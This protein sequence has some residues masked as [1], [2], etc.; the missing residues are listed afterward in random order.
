MFAV[1][2]ITDLF[3][4]LLFSRLFAREDDR[5]YLFNPYLLWAGR[6]TDPVGR[7]VTD[8]LPG[9]T[10]RAA[11]GIAFL[12]LLAF[13]GA[14]LTFASGSDWNI[15]VGSTLAFHPR[16]GW[17]GAIAFSFLDFIV[18]LV[19]FWGLALLVA[20][21]QS[22][23]TAAPRMRQALDA[24][25]A[26]LANGPAW[27][28]LLAILTANILLAPLLRHLATV[29]LASPASPRIAFSA[30]FHASPPPRLAAAYAGVALLSLAD[31][32]AFL[33]GALIIAIFSSLLAAIFRNRTLATFFLELQNLLLGRFSRRQIGVGMFDF[34][35]ILFFIALNFLYG[36]AITIVLT[37][38]RHFGIFAAGALAAQTY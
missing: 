21:L 24:L 17:F 22:S 23:Q 7:F 36:G 16:A 18:F 35:P 6:L 4:L 15:V 28:R 37:L 13:R 8:L 2:V 32:L 38:L 33:R 11:Y 12:F 19:R 31:N 29:S 20:H 1:L 9:L 5:A 30:L 10:I 3:L 14:V 25:A 27:M 26:P 34:T